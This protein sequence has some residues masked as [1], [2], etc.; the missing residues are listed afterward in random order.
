MSEL[1]VPFDNT[2][3]LVIQSRVVLRSRGQVPAFKIVLLHKLYKS[4]NVAVNEG[5]ASVQ[6]YLCH[7]IQPYEVPI[8]DSH[9][10]LVPIKD[11]HTWLAKLRCSIRAIHEE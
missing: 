1:T 10:W 2:D 7:P 3:P 4:I 8:K 5:L 9:T 6:G 11:S